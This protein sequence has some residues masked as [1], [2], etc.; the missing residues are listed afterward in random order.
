MQR[1]GTELHLLRAACGAVAGLILSACSGGAVAALL[2]NRVGH[3]HHGGPASVAGGLG[4]VVVA[5]D[6]RVNRRTEL[7]AVDLQGTSLIDLSGSSDDGG[8]VERMGV[9]PD[10]TRVAFI[11]A[12]DDED[13][14]DEQWKDDDEDDDSETAELWVAD[15]LVAGPPVKMHPDL[16]KGRRVRDCKWAPDSTRIAYVADQETR[17]VLQLFTSLAAGGGNVK[18][19][20]DSAGPVIFPKSR[21][22]K[23]TVAAFLWSPDSRYLACATEDPVTGAFDLFVVSPDG[24]YARRIAPADGTGNGLPMERKFDHPY[25]PFEWSTDPALANHVAYLVASSA[26]KNGGTELRIAFVDGSGDRRISHGFDPSN[27]DPDDLRFAWAPDGRRIV[28]AT[29]GTV[30]DRV[31]LWSTDPRTTDPDRDSFQVSK[32]TSDVLLDVAFDERDSFAWAPNSSLVAFRGDLDCASVLELFVADPSAPHATN[33]KINVP[34]KCLGQDVEVF[35]WSPDSSRIAYIADETTRDT[36]ELFTASPTGA[37]HAVVSRSS[38]HSDVDVLFEADHDDP[39]FTALQHPI[40]WSPDSRRLAYIADQN[41]DGVFEAFA[42]LADGSNRFRICGD[43]SLVGGDACRVTWRDSSLL[44]Y[45]ADQRERGR[46]ELFSAFTDRPTGAILT[47]SSNRGG[48]AC[49]DFEI[50]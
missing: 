14:V 16:P 36:Y 32:A 24:T 29:D 11:V 46:F 49:P 7:F 30:A 4:S 15:L 25:L 28:Y 22:F 3:D 12:T 6:L 27:D 35:R 10:R 18:A 41:V 2:L 47:G 26:C 5:T 43:L 37:D 45:A 33:Y 1:T 23:E 39:G 31:E 48:T 9:S 42:A 44:L 40:Q 38:G 19:S 8:R 50:R 13:D 21:E 34:L 17:G 20:P